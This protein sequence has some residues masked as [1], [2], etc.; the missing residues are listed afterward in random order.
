MIKVQ[1][2]LNVTLSLEQAYTLKRILDNIGGSTNGPRAGMDKIRDELESFSGEFENLRKIEITN[3][4]SI[5]VG[6]Y[7]EYVKPIVTLRKKYCT[8]YGP[9]DNLKVIHTDNQ[10]TYY[11]IVT[12]PDKGAVIQVHTKTS[13]VVKDGRYNVNTPLYKQLELAIVSNDQDGT[14]Y[15]NTVVWPGIHLRTPYSQDMKIKR[16]AKSRMHNVIYCNTTYP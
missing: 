12:G 14:N 4:R 8:I 11:K 7:V 15:V 3:A 1:K 2:T 10:F 6:M 5:S 13:K 16:I 9:T